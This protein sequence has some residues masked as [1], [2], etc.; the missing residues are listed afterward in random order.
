MTITIENRTIVEDVYQSLPHK[1]TA[2]AADYEGGDTG[3]H[4]HRRGQLIYAATGVMRV[5]TDEGCWVV[6]PLRGVWIPPEIMHTVFM[7][8]K[9]KMR[10][11]YIRPDI[12]NAFTANCSLVE[13]SPLLRSLVIALTEERVDYEENG[14]GGLIADLVLLE[15]KWLKTPA[16]HL[17]LPKDSNL[18]QICQQIIKR[19]DAHITIEL[20]ADKLAM[21]PRTLARKFQ[22]ETNLSFRQWRQQARLIEALGKLADHQPVAKVAH[23]LGYSNPSAFTAMFKRALGVEPSR[24]F[25]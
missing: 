25:Q 18:M 5:E 13:A 12:A 15:I 2:K 11:L 19:P 10:T 17:P 20:L 4:C 21:S 1:V 7:L 6:P 9:V 14:R 3:R 16:L 23:D 24:Y 8:S 22:K